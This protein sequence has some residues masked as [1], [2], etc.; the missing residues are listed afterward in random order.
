MTATIDLS[1]HLRAMRIDGGNIKATISKGASQVAME[2]RACVRFN[3]PEAVSAGPNSVT[4]GLAAVC[5]KT[6]PRDRITMA[7]RKNG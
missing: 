1:I 6:T 4:Y 3:R 5:N 7:P 2:L